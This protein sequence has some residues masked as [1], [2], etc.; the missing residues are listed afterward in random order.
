MSNPL[1]YTLGSGNVFA[2]L[3][4]PDA[5]EALLK[6]QLAREIGAAIREKQL[7]QAAAGALLGLDQPKV[8]ALVRG[9]LTG[10]S[11]E[12]LLRCLTAL[13]RDVTITVG[14]KKRER[15]QVELVFVP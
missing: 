9:R 11:V 15:G 12:R 2:D 5:E 3:H 6:A 1:E 4:H 8:S 10:F 13:E 7:T 14:P